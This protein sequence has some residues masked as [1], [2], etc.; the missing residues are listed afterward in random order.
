VSATTQGAG[1]G[2]VLGIVFVLLAQQLA[3][4]SLSSLVPSLEYLII[5]AVI[6]GVIFAVIGWAL[7]RLYERRHPPA[8]MGTSTTAGAPPSS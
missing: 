3:Y 7:G 5:G 4:I 2:V 1:C 6:G 8:S